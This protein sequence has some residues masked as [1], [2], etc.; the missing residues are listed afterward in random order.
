MGR[1]FWNNWGTKCECN[2]MNCFGPTTAVR[3]DRLFIT[4]REHLAIRI[5]DIIPTSGKKLLHLVG[6]PL[7]G[8]MLKN[9]FSNISYAADLATLIMIIALPEIRVEHSFVIK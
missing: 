1:G 5:V 4:D 6:S 7:A 9:L 2:K 3:R 8:K